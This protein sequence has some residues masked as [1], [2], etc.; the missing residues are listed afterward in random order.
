MSSHVPWRAPRM[1]VAAIGLAISLAA[2]AVSGCSSSPITPPREAS[3]GAASPADADGSPGVDAAGADASVASLDGPATTASPDAAN[4]GLDGA[5]A[6]VDA[7]GASAD[8]SG[9]GPPGPQGSATIY[10]DDLT[11]PAL[12]AAGE[13]DQALQKRGFSVTESALAQL[14][15]TAGDAVRVVIA[16]ASPDILARL[17]GQGGASVGPLKPQQYAIRV[18]KSG[19][20]TWYW[21]LG[22]DAAGAMYGGLEIAEH[23]RLDGVAAIVPADHTPYIENRGIKLNIPL[24]ART[25]SYS[26]D[27]DAAWNNVEVMWD[28]SF[29]KDLLDDMARY[30]YNALSI[31]NLNP[32]PSMVKVPGFEDVSLAD[33]KKNTIVFTSDL[34]GNGMAPPAVLNSA[35]TVKTMTID[36]KVAFWQQVMQYAK[37][38]GVDFYVFTWNVFTFGTQG[39][40]GITQSQTN[41]ATIAYVRAAVAQMV[42]SYP[43]LAGFGVTAGE[44]MTNPEKRRGSTTRTGLASPTR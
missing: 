34:V 41:P 12:F 37:D 7:Y 26:D 8:S 21:A 35:V 38:R 3:T 27:G 10:R 28:M 4:A 11:A 30:R 29:W 2:L 23:V 17:L 32:F 16:V 6:S 42:V 33:V 36:E 18:T 22:G 9:S 5:A 13:A 31:W 43:L 20:T 44:A 19:S 24:D 14:A 40:H 25:P 1:V 15:S 39:L